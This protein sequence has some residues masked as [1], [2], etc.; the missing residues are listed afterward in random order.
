VLKKE[1]RNHSSN[2]M[3]VLTIVRVAIMNMKNVLMSF[4]AKIGPQ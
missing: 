1:E 3:P 4:F 2:T